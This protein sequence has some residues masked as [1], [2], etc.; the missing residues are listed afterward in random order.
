MTDLRGPSPW[1]AATLEREVVMARLVDADPATAFRAWTDPDQIVQW[2]GPAGFDIVSHDI[3]I[4]EGGVWVFDMVAPDGTVFPN[5]MEF[6]TVRPD[7]L[8]E[9]L[10]GGGEGDPDTFRMRVSFD[11]QDNGKTAV[12]LRQMHPTAERRRVVVGF[13][14]VEF[15]AQT[16]DKFAAHVARKG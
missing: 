15:G 6:L 9:F 13:G 1:D 14:A 8:I 11:A 7:S 10:H 16:W 4:R 12:T 3:D 2:F 5:R